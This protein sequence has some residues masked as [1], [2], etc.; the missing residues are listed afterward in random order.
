MTPEQS[1]LISRL[2]AQ[3]RE[4]F[5]ERAGIL[6]YDCKI[7]RTDAESIAFIETTSAITKYKSERA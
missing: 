4:Y 1:E 5:N 2:D 7:P 6:E 3:W